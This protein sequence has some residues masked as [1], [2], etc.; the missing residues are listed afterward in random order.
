MTV[1]G[2]TTRHLALPEAKE[3]FL[4]PR[5]MRRERLVAVAPPKSVEGTESWLP[6]PPDWGGIHMCMNTCL[7]SWLR[8][9]R[10]FALY[11]PTCIQ[12]EGEVSRDRRFCIL[13]DCA[14]VPCEVVPVVT[15]SCVW[16]SYTDSWIVLT[17]CDVFFRRVLQCHEKCRM[18]FSLRAATLKEICPSISLGVR[19]L[20]SGY[21]RPSG[22][23]I[24]LRKNRNANLCR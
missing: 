16:Q 24:T 3:P 21:Q 15:D 8:N 1:R 13:V 4:F 19:N 22:T 2:R 9:N 5:A 6:V 14:D 7:A 23:A 17:T 11:A 20:V 10:A 18:A 12:A